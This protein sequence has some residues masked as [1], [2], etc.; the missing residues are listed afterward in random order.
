MNKIVIFFITLFVFGSLYSMEVD[1]SAQSCAGTSKVTAPVSF[2]RKSQPE[3]VITSKKRL[4][5]DEKSKELI[6]VSIPSDRDM[7]QARCLLLESSHSDDY[8]D[9]SLKVLNMGVNA[10]CISS[11]GYTPLHN[12]VRYLAP[13]TT[14][15]LLEKGANPL[16]QDNTKDT[17]LHL[18]VNYPYTWDETIY[19]IKSEMITKLLEV[20]QRKDIDSKNSFGNTALLRLLDSRQ[21]ML[22]KEYRITLANKLL[23]AG[24]NPTLQNKFKKN[25]IA[26]AREC[27]CDILASEM[28]ALVEARR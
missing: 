8:Y 23:V 26:L 21:Q 25:A 12:A 10:N 1:S 19:S 2:K 17:P 27:G 5:L 4:E 22:K 14:Q 13:K 6:K 18:A 7:A 16:A 15:L 28:L 9:S 11:L 24:A 20:I 3:D